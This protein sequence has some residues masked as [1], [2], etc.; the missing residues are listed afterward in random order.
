MPCYHPLKGYRS[1][2]LTENGKRKIV[3]NPKFG[4]SD[5]PVEVPCGQCIGCRLERSRQWAMR[6]TFEASMH[7]H[8]CFITL[9]YDDANLPCD[10]S[11]NLAHFQRFMKRLRKKFGKNIR[12]Y[13]CGEYG[14]NFGR[15]H[16]H[17]I[18]FGLDFDDKYLWS[19]NNGNKLYRSEKL[20]KLWPYGYSSIGEVTFESCAYVARY[21]MK[22]VNGDDADEHYTRIDPDTGEVYKV[23]PE[24]TTMSRRPGIAKEWFEKY[25][26]DVY[27]KDFV[28][29]RGKKMKAPKY[30]DGLYE[31]KDPNA[32][33]KLKRK[34]KLDSLKHADN[35]T[36][37]RLEVREIIQASKLKQLKRPLK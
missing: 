2:E 30:F 16:Y 24:Y 15:P 25:G 4:Y 23:K 7:K 9:T 35:N 5:L 19:V 20:E 36:S 29:I 1:K 18:I 13:H 27:P 31:V 6:C 17:A 14:E 33:E 12:F 3:F 34:R 22:K 11:L 28:T 10:S 21:I 32:F 8:N 26:D 37:E